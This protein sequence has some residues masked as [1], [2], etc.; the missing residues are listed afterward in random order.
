MPSS[1]NWRPSWGPGPSALRRE[2]HDRSLTPP[3]TPG[4]AACIG[5]ATPCGECSFSRAGHPVAGPASPRTLDVV[6]V[7]AVH[8]A[9]AVAAF[10]VGSTLV[11]LVLVLVLPV[12]P[13]RSSNFPILGQLMLLSLVG[14]LLFL[15][16][17]GPASLGMPGLVAAFALPATSIALLFFG[18]IGRKSYAALLCSTS[19]WN[20][21]GGIS[22]YVAAT[23][24]I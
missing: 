7:R 24:S 3:S 21:F 23:G 12:P 8:V 17:S 16:A 4:P 19:I 1:L 22:T 5:P 14:P 13:S 18:F 6:S 20:V 10:L 11:A 2:G 9:H 15:W